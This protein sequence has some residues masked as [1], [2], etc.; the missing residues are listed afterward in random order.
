MLKGQIKAF[1][2]SRKMQKRPGSLEAGFSTTDAFKVPNEKD[3]A[4]G[5]Q[6][7]EISTIPG[8]MS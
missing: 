5:R 7:H 3:V 1:S 2:L 8:Y 4:S 6:D